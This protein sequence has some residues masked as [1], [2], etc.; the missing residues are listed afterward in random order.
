MG[1]LAVPAIALAA[2]DV[3]AQQP[4]ADALP[5]ELS[6]HDFLVEVLRLPADG[7]RTEADLDRELAE[8][9]R[10]LGISDPSSR[11]STS[12]ADDISKRNT[13]S[14][15]SAT[16]ATTSHGRTFSSASD[17]SAA[18]TAIT[19]Q[20]SVVVEAYNASAGNPTLAAAP[21]L[22][23]RRSKSLSFSHYE[24]YLQ[25]IDPNINQPKFLKEPPPDTIDTSAQSLFSVST[26]R[27]YVSIKRGIKSRM[28][29][30]KKTAPSME[31]TM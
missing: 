9:A 2:P 8:R 23:R 27:S 20:S 1:S 31:E 14:A 18:S 24:K 30:R 17:G 26:R 29:W 7:K 5:P 12:T 10:E 15:E 4:A 28:R 19:S 25:Q 21:T 11:P 22:S 6:D 13:S 3:A 16:T